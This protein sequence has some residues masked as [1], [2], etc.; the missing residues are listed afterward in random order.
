MHHQ[1]NRDYAL[2]AHDPGG[3]A[4]T[5]RLGFAGE[6]WAGWAR[7]PEV[8]LDY[9]NANMTARRQQ[10]FERWVSVSVSSPSH[11]T[12]ALSFFGVT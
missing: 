9:S 1:L 11:R 8:V 4:D 10:K 7:D 6:A 2:S 3:C 5:K 12:R